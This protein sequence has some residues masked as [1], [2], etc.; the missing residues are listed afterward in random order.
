MIVRRVSYFTFIVAITTLATVSACN[1]A[2]AMNALKNADDAALAPCLTLSS[3][4]YNA[5]DNGCTAGIKKAL[6][7]HGINT[8]DFKIITAEDGSG[9]TIEVCLVLD[10]DYKGQV[11][12]KIFTVKKQ[13]HTAF[14]IATVSNPQLTFAEGYI[15][16][17]RDVIACK[18]R[19]LLE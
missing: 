18:N 4:S 14:E 16:D 3:N 12:A 15:P 2:A 6:L 10:K 1:Q 9:N 8:D 13:A 5:S 11:S 7:A 17:L 19:V